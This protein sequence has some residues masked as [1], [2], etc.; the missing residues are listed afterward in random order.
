MHTDREDHEISLLLQREPRAPRH[1][2]P[3]NHRTYL[4]IK[5][6]TISAEIDSY[7]SAACPAQ[8]PTL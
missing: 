6:T 8:S 4:T 2:R 3:Q 7:K 1:A 5:I